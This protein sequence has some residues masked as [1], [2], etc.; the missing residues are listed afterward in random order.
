MKRHVI[1]LHE[2]KK[3]HKCSICDRSFAR[4]DRLK[5]HVN[6]V[7]EGKMHNGQLDNTDKS[8]KYSFNLKARFEI[9]VASLHPDAQKVI[10]HTCFL[11]EYL[12]DLLVQFMKEETLN[13][14]YLQ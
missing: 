7:H 13:I 8:S 2:G 1:S 12:S 11:A 3:D 4:K 5:E 14:L 6:I 10:K 9:H